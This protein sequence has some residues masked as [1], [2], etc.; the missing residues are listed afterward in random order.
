[1]TDPSTLP[2]PRGPR[3]TRGL[4]RLPAVAPLPITGSEIADRI[5]CPLEM[6]SRIYHELVD[7]FF[8]GLMGFPTQRVESTRRVIILSRSLCDEDILNA[9]KE[10]KMW[11]DL[12]GNVD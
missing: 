11:Y 2:A 9:K 4:R 3:R 7:A 6:K 10:A 8:L 5:W 12:I 1:M